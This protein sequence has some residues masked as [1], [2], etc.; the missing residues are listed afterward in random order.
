MLACISFSDPTF[1]WLRL[2]FRRLYFP[3]LAQEKWTRGGWL[4][5]RFM[6]RCHSLPNQFRHMCFFI[7]CE[8]RVCF[9]FAHFIDFQRDLAS[10]SGFLVYQM[11]QC[12]THSRHL[13]Y[14]LCLVQCVLVFGLAF[15]LLILWVW[16]TAFFWK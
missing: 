4:F 11:A 1:G 6:G 5:T 7:G 10:L 16:G 12:I 9:T 8:R 2:I 15:C 3:L 14:D 13:E